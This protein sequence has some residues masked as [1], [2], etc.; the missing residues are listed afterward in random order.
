MLLPERL[1]LFISASVRNQDL[2]RSM[3]KADAFTTS[4]FLRY[5]EVPRLERISAVM[6][7]TGLSRTTIYR[8]VRAGKFPRWIRIGAT[9]VWNAQDVSDWILSKLEGAQDSNP[10][11]TRFVEMGLRSG[12]V[13]RGEAV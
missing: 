8:L 11:S 7:R 5:S 10:V 1:A 3:T 4:P 13:R 2:L 6:A 9:S 12:A